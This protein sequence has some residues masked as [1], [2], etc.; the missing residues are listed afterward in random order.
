MNPVAA[1]TLIVVAVM[2]AL[3]YQHS[4]E[5]SNAVIHYQHGH[6]AQIKVIHYGDSFCPPNCGVRHRHRVHDIRWSCFLADDCDHFTVLHAVYRGDKNR[7]AALEKTLQASDFTA[8]S[9]SN[10]IA[11]ER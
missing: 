7:M 5:R 11:S 3:A 9:S 6:A 1:V 10:I 4:V 8:G 2:G